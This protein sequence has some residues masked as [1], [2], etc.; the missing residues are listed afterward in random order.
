MCY[1][2]GPKI[3]WDIHEKKKI[4]K[5]KNDTWH[6]TCDMWHVAGDTRCLTLDMWHVTLDTWDNV[7]GEHSLKMSAL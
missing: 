5:E 3:Y 2:L 6:M 7:G 1:M 4:K